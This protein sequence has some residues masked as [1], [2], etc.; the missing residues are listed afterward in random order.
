[1]IHHLH[2]VCEKFNS[3]GEVIAADQNHTNVVCK[4]TDNSTK[5]IGDALV[6]KLKKTPIGVLSADCIPIIYFDE[7]NEVIA[8]SHNGWKGIIGEITKNTINEMELLGAKK[9]HIK[10]IIGPGVGQCCYDVFG[11]RKI[12]FEKTFKNNLEKIFAKRKKKF[13]LDLKS[14]VKLQLIDLEIRE[15][16]IEVSEICTSC[17]K[18]LPSYKRDGFIKKQILTYAWME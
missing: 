10:C 2:K 1:M 5:H 12:I 15:S 13:F 7:I 16:N 11:E 8:V 4:V 6:T 9:E 14:C 3:L 17:L 18:T